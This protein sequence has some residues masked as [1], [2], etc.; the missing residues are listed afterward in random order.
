MNT[1]ESEKQKQ[2]SENARQH[3]QR[4]QLAAFF[5]GLVSAD[6][7]LGSFNCLLTGS[8]VYILP[9]PV[10]CPGL[11]TEPVLNGFCSAKNRTVI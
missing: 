4:F 1:P 7:E 5:L 8:S 10:A 11:A 9:A 3:K 6:K 2:N